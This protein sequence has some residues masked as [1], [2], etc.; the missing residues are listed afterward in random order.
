MIEIG[1]TL[2]RAR[3]R[4]GLDL[5][6]AEDATR[7]RAHYLQALEQEQF[8][9]LPGGSYRRSFLRT[10]A[11]FLGLDS[12]VLVDEYAARFERE[13]D[14]W[15]EPVLARAVGP[16]L[17]LPY[18]ALAGAVVV[19]AAIAGLAAYLVQGPGSP[20][21]A[22][23]GAV[24]GGRHATSPGHGAASRPTK[25]RTT[26][27]ASATAKPVA[28]SLRIAAVTGRCWLSARRGSAQGPLV[29]EGTLQPG[30]GVDLHGTRFW[31]RF[32]APAAASLTLD[33]KQQT[34]P[35]RTGDI[36]V[37]AHGVRPTA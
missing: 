32:G 29:Y 9:R 8:D 33:G 1:P 27:A 22:T 36:L 25:R 35:G 10:Y 6:E 31:I 17:R 5:D 28:V 23:T 18:G 26:T 16:R 2:T 34:L 24:A 12:D 30:Q 4:L 20:P 15:P 7:L 11:D 21:R 37:D 14:E 13:P 3:V 19:V